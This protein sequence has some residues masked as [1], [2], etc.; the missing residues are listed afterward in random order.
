[1]K[2]NFSKYLTKDTVLVLNGEN[3]FE[4]LDELITVAS[5]QS[6]VDRDIIFRAAWKREKM[7]TTG[8]GFGL[9]LPHVRLNSIP[10]PVIVVGV[11]KEPI[12]DYESHDD[13]PV[14]VLVFI[15]A[16]DRNQQE[17]LQLLG[18]VSRKLR[19]S[20]VIQEIIDS[21]SSPSKILKTLKRCDDDSAE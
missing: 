1:M 11:T 8:V 15:V 19:H 21:V 10:D 7:M 9:A 3:K 20:E 5:I 18:S 14:R 16:P 4:V 17:Y 6:K 12:T 13:E 2:M